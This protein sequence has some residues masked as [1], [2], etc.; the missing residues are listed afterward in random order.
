MSLELGFGLSFQNVR[1]CLVHAILAIPFPRRTRRPIPNC[2]K[3]NNNLEP[4]W[5]LD[6]KA[7]LPVL[8]A[9]CQNEW[10]REGA[11]LPLFPPHALWLLLW[12]R[13]CQPLLSQGTGID[14]LVGHQISD[15]RL[16]HFSSQHVSS[17][18]DTE[19]GRGNAV[20]AKRG[21]KS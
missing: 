11:H 20:E 8:T 18:A 3:Q 16:F 7:P 10:K 4:P 14:R 19:A 2:T 1:F 6:P 12:V 15:F 5:P 9:V 17:R 21:I 13:V